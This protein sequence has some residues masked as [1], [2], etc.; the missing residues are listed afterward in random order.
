ML[1]SMLSTV[2]CQLFASSLSRLSP[3]AWVLIA[4]IVI[5]TL[6]INIALIA[7]LRAKTPPRLPRHGRGTLG[8]SQEL[9]KIGQVMRDPLGKE[10]RQLNELSRLVEDFKRT[11]GGEKDEQ[12]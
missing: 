5:F 8:A 9:E 6:A 12:K 3:L 2:D 4:I 1:L 11:S 7:L 10:R